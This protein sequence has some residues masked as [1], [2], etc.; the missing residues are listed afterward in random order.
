MKG[1]ISEFELGVLRTRMVE[2]ARAKAPNF[3][4]MRTSGATAIGGIRRQ[5]ATCRIV[6]PG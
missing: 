2:A 5:S 4:I 1:S 6:T 3:P